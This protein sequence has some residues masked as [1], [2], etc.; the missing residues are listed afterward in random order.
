[1]KV[2]YIFTLIMVVMTVLIYI[3][4][5]VNI[6]FWREMDEIIPGFYL[7]NL[8]DAQNKLLLER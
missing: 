5:R 7:G 6:Y 1:M 8:K 3:A 2:V 4:Y